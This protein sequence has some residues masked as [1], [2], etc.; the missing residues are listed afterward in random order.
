MI[1]IIKF[2]DIST[3]INYEPYYIYP[4][5][6]SYLD[7]FFDDYEEPSDITNDE[8]KEINRLIKLDYEDYLLNR[9]DGAPNY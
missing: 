2:R 9:Y 6:L 7:W 8:V 5:E 1:C 4:G 3:T